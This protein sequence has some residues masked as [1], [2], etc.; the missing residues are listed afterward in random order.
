[1]DE[2]ATTPRPPTRRPLWS[3]SGFWPTVGAVLVLVA[4]GLRAELPWVEVAA[5]AL[6]VVG[7]F[8]GASRRASTW[9][10]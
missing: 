7:T 3:R 2:Q 8:L 10:P 6:V 5:S 4:Q 9:R 1:M